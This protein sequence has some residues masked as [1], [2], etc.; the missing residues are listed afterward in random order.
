MMSEI[1]FNL[2]K[3]F[4]SIFLITDSHLQAVVICLQMSVLTVYGK[5]RLYQN[6]N[7]N[8]VHNKV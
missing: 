3:T 5:Y 8:F 4:T 1:G 2:P 7:N 6:R